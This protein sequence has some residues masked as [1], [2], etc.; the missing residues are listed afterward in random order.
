VIAR[1]ATGLN[2]EINEGAL[3]AFC[4]RILGWAPD[5]TDDV[6]HAIDSIYLNIGREAV[7]VLLGETDLVPLAHALHRRTLGDDQPFIVC[8]RHRGDTS[9][10][11]RSP[12]NYVSGV[13]TFAAATGGSLCVRHSRPPKDFSSL[14]ALVRDPSARVQLIVC[15]D[16]RHDADPFITLPVPIRVPSLRTRTSELPRIVDEYAAD[17]IAELKVPETSF[18]AADRQWVIE[19]SPM[20]LGE[21]EKATLR[22]VALETSPSLPRAAER[23][24]MAPV[25]LARWL[26]RWKQRPALARDLGV[27]SQPLERSS[28]PATRG[29]RGRNRR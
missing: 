23:L 8:D 13:A 5:R 15:A 11:V 7:L 22:L 20:T 29:K 24:G 3:R 18:T 2:V 1:A 4:A 14:V 12:D 21:I 17:A 27:S 9:A 19:H 28:P 10:S 16:A 26:K 25:S 6:E